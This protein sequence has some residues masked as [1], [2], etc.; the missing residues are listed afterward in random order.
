MLAGLNAKLSITTLSDVVAVLSSLELC[1]L[2]FVVVF[3]GGAVVLESLP[4]L[5]ASTKAPTPMIKTAATMIPIKVFRF[6]SLLS[7]FTPLFYAC[8]KHNKKAP[9][10]RRVLG[11]EGLIISS[12]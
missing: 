1:W 11:R 8:V 7:M 4:E 9:L 12:W 3:A 5:F 2:L 6:I 10:L